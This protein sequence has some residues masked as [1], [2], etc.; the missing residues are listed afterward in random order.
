MT[1]PTDRDRAQ[2]ADIVMRARFSGAGVQLLAEAI[3]AIRIEERERRQSLIE[4]GDR[5]IALMSRCSDQVS[6]DIRN[7]HARTMAQLSEIWGAAKIRS[8]E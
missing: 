8:G 3:A 5:I 2:A 4:A 6:D 1:E 7:E